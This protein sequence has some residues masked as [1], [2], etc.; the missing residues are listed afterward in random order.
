MKRGHLLKLVRAGAL[1]LSLMILPGVVA[2]QSN[3]NGNTG[4]NTS[5]TRTETR[6]EGDERKDRDF[7][8]GWLGL[9]GLAGLLGLMPR[10]RSVQVREMPAQHN[11]GPAPPVNPNTADRR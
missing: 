3:N 10:K 6:V 5:T 4:T 1:G 11:P 9:L 8:W 2:A 7:D